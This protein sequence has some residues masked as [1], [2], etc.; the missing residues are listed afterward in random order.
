MINFIK[1][2][3]NQDISFFGLKFDRDK[4]N[5]YHPSLLRV[6]V[7]PFEQRKFAKKLLSLIH[8]TKIHLLKE[9][10]S[11]NQ[12]KGDHFAYEAYL[13]IIKHFLSIGT[14][15][16]FEKT[17]Q[18]QQG[19]KVEWGKTFSQKDFIYY[20][21]QLVPKNLIFS[22][23]QKNETIMQTI[24]Q[25]CVDIGLS[26]LGWLFSLNKKPKIRSSQK[27]Q[28]YLRLIN[29]ALFQTFNDQKIRLLKMMKQII[30]NLI[31]EESQSSHSFGIQKFDVAFEIMINQYFHGTVIPRN[32]LPSGYWF[33][34]KKNETIKTSTLRPD[35]ITSIKDHMFIIDAKYYT[36]INADLSRILPET[37]DIL[38]Q[39]AYKEF[40]KNSFQ[41]HKEI[42]N[43]FLLPKIDGQ[44]LNDKHHNEFKN[45][46]NYLG[47]ASLKL[48]Q[49][50]YIVEGIE[51][52]L[53]YLFK[54]FD[55]T[56]VREVSCFYDFIIDSRKEIASR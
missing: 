37:S 1:S 16:E 18:K 33:L 15:I 26:R 47:K 20:Q 31:Q 21:N 49:Q 39:I 46:F 54:N 3:R 6:P 17:F 42:F 52:E 28:L 19:T 48:N 29:Q 51:I 23:Y 9:T 4:V 45:Y 14:Y 24:Y 43:L 56:T 36:S 2:S 25:Y 35:T 50:D 10:F 44:G 34:A 32:F 11:T 53:N 55:K 8:Q 40:L 22:T 7:E 30:S 12:G 5:L 13:F 38:K 41:D 27:E